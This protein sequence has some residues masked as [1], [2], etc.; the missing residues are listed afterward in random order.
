MQAIR[1]KVAPFQS[2]V[3][4]PSD[5]VVSDLSKI[6]AAYVDMVDSN[7]GLV[8]RVLPELAVDPEF[9]HAVVPAQAAVVDGLR[10]V[11]QSHQRHGRLRPD[12]VDDALRAFMGPLAARD[13][14]SHLLD[15][16]PFDARAYVVRFLEGWQQTR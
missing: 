12:P 10:R 2:A 13:L 16:S 15:R 3:V 1:E 8:A 14:M 11:I 6:A 5:D 4:E 9:R 7:P